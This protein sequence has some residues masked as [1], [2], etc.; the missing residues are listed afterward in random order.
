MNNWDLSLEK[1]FPLKSESRF[2][3][4]RLEAY[5][6]WNH[7]QFSGVN[8]SASFNPGGQQVNAMFGQVTSTRTPRVMQVSLR[9]TF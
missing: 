7:T 9:A 2:F 3:Q 5:N 6:A 8:T 1:K 4:L